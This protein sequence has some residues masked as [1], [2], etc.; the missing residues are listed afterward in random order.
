MG[1]PAAATPWFK[2]EIEYYAPI[3]TLSAISFFLF[4]WAEINRYQDL[5]N[6]GSVSQ[7]PIFSN[8]KVTGAGPGYPGFDP[9]GYSK[10]PEFASYKLK[11]IKNGRLA[12]VAFAGFAAQALVLG[13]GPLESL[14]A[15]LAD[16]WATTVWQN[17]A[18]EIPAKFFS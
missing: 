5:V 14:G 11:E 15:H 12:M 13:K 17:R 8:N 1:G 6:P 7:D 4:S 16:P 9:L 18:G 2:P 10:S 3:S